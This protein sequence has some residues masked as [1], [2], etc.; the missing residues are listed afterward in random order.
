MSLQNA[1]AFVQR[2]KSDSTLASGLQNRDDVV[3]A[4]TEQGVPFT[5]AELDQAINDQ[6][7][8]LSEADLKNTA[9]GFAAWLCC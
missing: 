6:Y 4:A 7:G 8:D 3:R 5:L 2:L 9:G 1:T